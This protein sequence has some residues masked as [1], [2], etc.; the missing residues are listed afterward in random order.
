MFRDSVTLDEVVTL[1]NEAITL[2]PRAMYNL[3]ESRVECNDALAAHPTI[4]V[5]REKKGEPA[6]VGLIGII[7]G[8]FGTDDRGHGAIAFV[9]NKD[10]TGQCGD[11][12]KRV[13]RIDHVDGDTKDRKLGEKPD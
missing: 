2:D 13:Q 9:Y 5:T 12:L 6:V 4:Q 3:A 1:I 7:E 8:L 10:T 11:V